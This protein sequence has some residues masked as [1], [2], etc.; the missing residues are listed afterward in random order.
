MEKQIHWIND[1]LKNAEENAS[2]E[3]VK[4]IEGCGRGCALESG[5]LEGMMPLKDEASACKTHEDY[6]A[7]F[8][9]KF[10]FFHAEDAGDGI[11]IHFHKESCTCP[12]APEVKNPM[13]CHCT[14]GHEKAM[15]G[16]LFG[17]TIDA[18]IVE[19]FQ[20]GGNDCVVKLYM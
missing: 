10:P 1:F 19:S 5:H 2:P 12:M 4:A 13:L 16:E 20:R 8:A 3:V 14:L 7:F 9:S 17:R 6:M 15:W 11:V 18:E